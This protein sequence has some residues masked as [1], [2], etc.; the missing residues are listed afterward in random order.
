MAHL[1]KRENYAT[2]YSLKYWSGTFE[3]YTRVLS[4]STTLYIGNLSFYT[5]E[6]QIWELFSKVGQIKRLLMGLNK[7]THTPCGF[8][9][10]EYYTHEAAEDCVY[11]IN[12]TKLDDRIIRVDWDTGFVE[13]RQ[14]GRGTNGGQIRDQFRDVYDPERSDFSQ[15]KKTHDV[16][17]QMGG[18]HSG[19]D[20]APEPGAYGGGGYMSGPYGAGSG[21][22]HRHP[23]YAASSSSFGGN[24][25][26]GSAYGAGGHSFSYGGYSGPSEGGG[27]INRYSHQPSRM[28]G[29]HAGRYSEQFD[30][31][32][33]GS[34]GEYQ[35]GH[36]HLNDSGIKRRFSDPDDRH[37]SETRYHRG[38]RHHRLREPDYDDSDRYRKKVRDETPLES[39]GVDEFGRDIPLKRCKTS[40]AE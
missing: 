33:G 14:Y 35:S 18:K 11:Y 40:A 20:Q 22:V 26:S 24:P 5:T 23:T 36:E 10:V 39:G 28:D 21:G 31:I 6:E 13:G 19:H 25:G 12:G 15:I 17:S 38:S 3:E 7:Y 30:H 4:K 37:I 8:C 32:L 29:Y 34:G 2:N 16:G 27:Y 9:F 1:Y